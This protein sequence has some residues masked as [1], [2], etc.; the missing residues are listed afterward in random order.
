M[1]ILICTARTDQCYNVDIDLFFYRVEQFNY[2]K[3]KFLYFLSTWCSLNKMD[4]ISKSALFKFWRFVNNNINVRQPVLCSVPKQK[5]ESD[6]IVCNERLKPSLPAITNYAS[7][8]GKKPHLSHGTWMQSSVSKKHRSSWATAIAGA[9][10]IDT[11]FVFLFV[12]GQRR[13]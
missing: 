6:S 10:R 3:Y 13:G 2:W 7:E 12:F 11:S 1:L 4:R 9:M 5:D 8:I